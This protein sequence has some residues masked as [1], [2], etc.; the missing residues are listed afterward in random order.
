MFCRCCPAAR[1]QQPLGQGRWQ[2]QMIVLW[3]AIYLL[4]YLG[5]T[6][7][8]QVSWI[9]G[10]TS[11]LM[12]VEFPQTWNNWELWA[13][14]TVKPHAFKIMLPNGEWPKFK[15]LFE[16][17]SSNNTSHSYS[18]AVGK[19]PCSVVPENRWLH[20]QRKSQSLHDNLS[21]EKSTVFENTCP[22]LFLASCRVV[23]SLSADWR[24]VGRGTTKIRPSFPLLPSSIYLGKNKSWV[25]ITFFCE[26]IDMREG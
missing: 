6:F 20:E 14:R 11:D 1:T 17:L 10:S 5:T 2:Q 7:C 18:E 8:L 4:K 21:I 22:K 23:S 9:L 16:N 26:D 19:S 24:T 12:P 15:N 3:N 13:S 25:Q